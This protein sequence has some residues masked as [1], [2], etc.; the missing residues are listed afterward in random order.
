MIR[1]N[2]LPFRKARAKENVRQQISVFL[3][4]FALLTLTMSYVA[5]YGN[6]KIAGM[7]EQ[8]KNDRQQLESLNKLTKEISEI[9]KNLE[10]IKK[11]TAVIKDLQLNRNSSAMLLDAMTYMVVPNRMWFTSLSDMGATVDIV[12]MALDNKT[13]ADFMVRLE[14]SGLFSAVKLRTLKQQTI[15]NV[16]IKNFDVSCTR[17]VKSVSAPA[18]KAVKK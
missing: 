15:R 14:T 3:L 13:V 17:I 7:D 12:G 4:A 8:I 5:M 6:R 9:K 11:K 1:I 10:I 18:G 2:L 16:T